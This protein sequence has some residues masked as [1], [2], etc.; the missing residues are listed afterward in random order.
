MVQT[1]RSLGFELT[2]HL[3]PGTIPNQ[4]QTPGRMQDGWMPQQHNLLDVCLHP[5]AMH[6]EMPVH[7]LSNSPISLSVSNLYLA[8]F[9]NSYS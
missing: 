5:L 3:L 7:V 8:S 4:N 6:N 9:M 2:E 1:S